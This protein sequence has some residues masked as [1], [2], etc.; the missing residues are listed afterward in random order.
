MAR[1]Q[2]ADKVGL[3][4]TLNIEEAALMCDRVMVLSSNPGTIAAEIANPLPHPRDRQDPVFHELVD[5]IYSVLTKRKVDTTP[6]AAKCN[7][8][9]AAQNNDGSNG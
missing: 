9:T 1:A 6:A 2:V 3:A 5:Q 8:T 4:L 7:R